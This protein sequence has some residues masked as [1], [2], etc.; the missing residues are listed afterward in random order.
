MVGPLLASREVVNNTRT[1]RDLKRRAD[2]VISLWTPY[3]TEKYTSRDDNH[4]VNPMRERP[5]HTA[6]I[7]ACRAGSSSPSKVSTAVARARKW[8][9]SRTRFAVTAYTRW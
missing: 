2:T 6:I 8:R 9:N 3:R 1:V 7:P 4:G 5:R